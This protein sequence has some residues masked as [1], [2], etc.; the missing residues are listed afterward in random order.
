M[1]TL[2]VKKILTDEQIKELKGAFIPASH[3]DTVIEEDC[4]VYHFE[5]GKKKLLFHFRKNYIPQKYMDVAI[6]TFKKDAAKASNLRRIASGHSHQ[7][8]GESDGKVKVKSLIAGYFD[9]PRIR[10]KHQ[11]TEQ[12]LVP[13]RTTSF[14]KNHKK[15]WEKIL[16]LID[17]LDNS[18]KKFQPSTHKKQL[19]LASITPQFQI[20]NT[21]FSTI[22]VN[23]N[24]RTA[25]HVDA[26]DFSEGYSIII[27][28]EEKPDTY[29]GGCLGYP[30][31]GVC[32]NVRNGDFLLK[33]PHQYHA[34]TEIIPLQ[35]DWTRLSFVFYYREN[36]QKCQQQEFIN[37][38]P[39]EQ[40]GGGK[41]ILQHIDL[42]K[43]GLDLSVY[44]RPNTTDEKV[45]DEVFKRNVYDKPKVN[46]TVC[47][48]GKESWLD[49]GGNIG[50]FSLVVLS[51][52]CRVVTC[53]P[54]PTNLELLEQNLQY[55][56][57]QTTSDH[58]RW[59]IEPV[60]V[61]S[62]KSNTVDLFLCKGDYNKYRHTLY[63]IR[64]R[65]TLSVKNIN[66][67]DL[68]D[69]YK[70]DCI[71]MDIEGAEID[72]LETLLPI[73]YKKY[74]IKKLVFEY[75]FDVDKSIPRFL[76]IIDNL[77]KHFLAV[78]YTKV[79]PTEL[80]YTY[81]PPACMVYCQL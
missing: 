6:Q 77:K 58:V 47:E 74:G 31:F 68:L 17:L 25:C 72:L 10:D 13:C 70:F 65:E 81:Y 30:Q 5:N 60:A 62:K 33:D 78:F 45:I 26:G 80:E 2:T 75:S 66:I 39:F 19:D 27:V 64:G 21:A 76:K 9:K 15:Q 28:A 14:T 4:D 20:D 55:N 67:Y 44:I 49:L 51:R 38:N 11:V 69:K 32:V 52:G 1:R 41:T 24:W 22:T 7:A 8:T 48:N 54:E 61:S 35:K 59:I 36:M 37:V 40:S 29:K 12:N 56:F 53:E 63:P 34:N 46:F 3:Y 57:P 43:R 71:K 50:T 16:P 79:N 23:Y 18:Y 42:P 73:D